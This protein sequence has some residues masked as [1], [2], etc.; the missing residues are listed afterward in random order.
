ME[1]PSEGPK[2]NG[3]VPRKNPSTSGRSRRLPPWR[4]QIRTTSRRKPRRGIPKRTRPK[5]RTKESPHMFLLRKARSLC[6]GL[7]T[8]TNNQG[9]NGPPRNTQIPTRTR[10]I[11]Q[12]ESNIRVVDDRSVADDR[13]P[14]QRATD[15]LTSVADEHDNVKDI[16]M[17]E[18][19][20]KE[21]FQ[22][23]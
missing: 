17:Q 18:L 14:Q 16:V 6:K 22:N 13:T 19:W 2:R 11:R 12:E 23:A 7:P 8:E 9:S 20:G 5:R 15:W 21:D 3:Y 1:E 10:Q 4:K